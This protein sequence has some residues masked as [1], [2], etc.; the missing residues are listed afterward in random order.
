MKSYLSVGLCQTRNGQ[1]LHMLKPGYVS[2]VRGKD[3]PHAQLAHRAQRAEEVAERVLARPRVEADVRRDV[4]QHMVAGEQHAVVL[5]IERRV[6]VGV[7][8]GPHHAQAAVAEVNEVPVIDLLDAAEAI[9]PAA[10]PEPRVAHLAVDVRGHAVPR[11][12]LERGVDEL[13]PAGPEPA[14][15][16]RL[17]AVHDDLRARG[18][19]R[20]GHADVVRM[21]VRD[22]D[23]ADV[24][25]GDAG[26]RERGAKGALALLG[27]KARV[28]ERPAARSLDEVRVDDPQREREGKGDEP[29]SGCDGCSDGHVSAKV[30]VLRPVRLE[31]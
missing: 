4:R 12:P 7:T 17:G 20:P 2:P 31:A 19:E 15:V 14:R 21:H 9:D 16:I 18:L 29:D 26:I 30:N 5:V 27:V 1:S 6:E 10:H 24:R 28:D 11:E 22:E 23:A 25:H 8:R 13:R 3:A